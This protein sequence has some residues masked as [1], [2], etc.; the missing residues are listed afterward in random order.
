[1]VFNQLTFDAC[2]CVRQRLRVR[3]S[4]RM[5]TYAHVFSRMPT[6]E[7]RMLTHAYVCVRE[8][9]GIREHT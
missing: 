1:M 5:L 9:L 7:E 3:A 6:K 8:R 4:E 2:V